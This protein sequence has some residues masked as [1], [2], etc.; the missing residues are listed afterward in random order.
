MD[1]FF[2][3]GSLLTGTGNPQVDEA[4]SGGTE[5]LGPG[6]IHARLY[7][8]GGYPGAVPGLAAPGTDPADPP[9]VWGRLFAVRDPEAFF[10]LL[11]DYE[12]FRP[13]APEAGEFFRTTT[14]IH[15]PRATRPV[16]GQI[17]F[18]N[19]RVAESQRIRSGDYSAFRKFQ[20]QA[21]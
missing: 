17:Y 6:F 8:L 21:D 15:L 3:Y 18:F 4:M 20:E 1:L 19:R 14:H 13:Q 9:T 7:E 16:M 10:A 12:D 11:D 2:A 5:E